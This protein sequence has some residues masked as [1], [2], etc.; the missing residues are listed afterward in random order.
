MPMDQGC[1]FALVLML[2]LLLGDAKP[3]KRG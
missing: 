2:A 3:T 1:E